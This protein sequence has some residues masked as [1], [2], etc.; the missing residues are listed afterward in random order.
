MTGWERPSALSNQDC[1][2]RHALS[3]RGLPLDA[4]IGVSLDI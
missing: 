3:I 4:I 2:A 1:V